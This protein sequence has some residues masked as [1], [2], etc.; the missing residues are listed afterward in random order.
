MH[1][2]TTGR[3]F[4]SNGILIVL[5]AS[6]CSTITPKKFDTGVSSF[7]NFATMWPQLQDCDE[8]VC[9]HSRSRHFY[10]REVR[11]PGSVARPTVCEYERAET[12][13]PFPELSLETNQRLGMAKPGEDEVALL[14]KAA[15]SR[16]YRTESGS[17]SIVADAPE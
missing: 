13:S 15:R 3:W 2:V 6:G 17:W 16:M 8:L 5:L 11:C 9:Y 12:D 10:I 14:W 7:D 1:F 4:D